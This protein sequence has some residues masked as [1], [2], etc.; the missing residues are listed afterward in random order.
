MTA[1]QKGFRVNAII[2]QRLADRK[3]RLRERLD[4]HNFPDDLDQPMLR[5]ANIHYE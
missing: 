3:R 4:K 5:A 1:S 2:G